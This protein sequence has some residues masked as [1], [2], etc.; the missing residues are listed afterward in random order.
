MMEVSPEPNCGESWGARVPRGNLEERKVGS[1][2]PDGGTG[3]MLGSYIG[4]RSTTQHPPRRHGPAAHMTCCVLD[5][6]VP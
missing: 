3:E 2:N 5:V 1:A 4:K 6:Y